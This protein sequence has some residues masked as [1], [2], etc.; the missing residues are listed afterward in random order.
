VESASSTDPLAVCETITALITSERDSD[1]GS[2]VVYPLLATLGEVGRRHGN[3]PGLLQAIL[4]ALHTY[5]VDADPVPRAAALKA[6]TTIGRTHALPSTVADL[7]P[8]LILDAYVVVIDA[9]LE[10]ACRLP[11]PDQESRSR[12]VLHAVMVMEGVNVSKHLDTFLT[13]LS[14]LRHYVPDPAALA[15]LEKKALSRVPELAWYQAKDVTEQP[16]QPDARVAP[17]L[18]VLWL[19]HELRRSSRC[20]GWRWHRSAL[21]GSGRATRPRRR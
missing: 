9:V 10:A 16:W 12:L 19:A 1:L 20:C 14:A 5:L 2:E 21:T 4:P 7:L 6:W 15:A 11:W 8:A 13:S 3:H 17:E 18:A